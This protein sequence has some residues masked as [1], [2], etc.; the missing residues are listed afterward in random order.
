MSD[1]IKT[2]VFICGGGPVGLL[3]A[4]SLALQGVTSVIVEKHDTAQQAMYGRAGTLYP[5][6]LEM[7]D[8]LQLLDELNQIGYIARNS[9][10]YK[11]GQLI[12]SRG[13]H[14]MYQRMHETFMDYIL[15]IRQKYSEDAFRAAYE[16]LGGTPYIGWQL[17][18]F[19]VDESCEDDYKVTSTIKNV[20]SGKTLT[21]KSKFI[22][23]A[24]GGHSLVRRLAN[25]ASEGDRTEFKWVRIDGHFRTDM[26]DADLGF[27]SIESE[28]HGNV[29]WVQMD[30]GVKRIGFAMTEEMLA[31]YG[32]NLTLEDAKAEAVKSMAPFTLEFDSITWWTLY[33]IGQR[34]A[35][36]FV[37]DDRVILA[38]DACHTHSS[39]AAQGMNTGVHDS[40]NL[41][42]K[43]GGAIKGWYSPEVLRTYDTE[44]RPAAQHLIHL[45]K[46]FSA[47]ISGK[48]PDSYKDQNI[49]A[50]ELFT[51][52][53]DDNIQFNIGLGIHYDENILNRPSLATMVTAGWRAPDATVYAPGSKF[54]IRLFQLTK[55]T[56]AWSI[57]ILAGHPD[58]TRKNLTHAIQELQK[59]QER[60]PSEMLRFIT[61]VAQAVGGGDQWYQIPKI[62]RLYYDAER[63]AHTAYT[64]SD[65]TGA[66]AIVR[67]DGLLGYATRLDD[68]SHVE[69]YFSG[70][71]APAYM[72]D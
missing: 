61:V 43:L 11:N 23:G 48:V 29:L 37:K 66:V 32:D 27:A 71:V 16:K 62:G 65:S 52:T 5:R 40:V 45:D 15:N 56:G 12:T 18:T 38:G 64:V 34:V 7:L 60:L 19:S 28:S 59:L 44:R 33:S 63:S 55:N 35:E 8:Q 6:T 42:W 69:E 21:V 26:P 68:L 17:E 9:V 51:K 22:V 10:T 1:P 3:T 50:D 58:K 20:S 39:G 49:T 13:W 41:S 72:K 25:I 31:K 36:T 30:H 24:D 2:D 57:V 4:Y 54:P 70:F 47:S 53:F 14:I 67:P 46:T